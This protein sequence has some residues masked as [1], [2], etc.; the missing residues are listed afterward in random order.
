MRLKS[1]VCIVL[2]DHQKPWVARRAN[3][4]SS[5][6][7]PQ[8]HGLANYDDDAGDDDH[9]DVDDDDNDDEVSFRFDQRYDVWFGILFGRGW[10]VT[11]KERKRRK[12]LQSCERDDN[13]RSTQEVG[14]PP[15][16]RVCSNREGGGGEEGEQP[17]EENRGSMDS[18]W[19]TERWSGEQLCCSSKHERERDSHTGTV[20]HSATPRWNTSSKKPA[21]NRQHK[22]APVNT[23]VV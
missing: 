3:L 2:V 16:G 12:S 20:P 19:Q 11:E 9:D 13:K 6:C 4:R 14:W 22:L 17:G 10:Q 5:T 7:G 1:E 8:P 23:I 15:L 21:E 18:E